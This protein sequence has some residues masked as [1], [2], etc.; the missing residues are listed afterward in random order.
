M[1]KEWKSQFVAVV[2]GER[3]TWGEIAKWFD[4][5]QPAGHW[6]GPISKTLPL[7]EFGVA[8]VTAAIEFYTGSKVEITAQGGG[9]YLV[10]AAGYYEAVGA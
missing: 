4:L 5:V 10:E 7:T 6:K 8:A 2:A 9:V 1:N 3:M